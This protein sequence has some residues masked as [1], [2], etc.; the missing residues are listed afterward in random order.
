M[1]EKS[2]LRNHAD[3]LTIV[4][5]N[6]AIAAILITMYVSNTSRIDAANARSDQLYMAL[7]EETLSFHQAIM[8]E[9]QLFHQ[10]VKDFHGRLCAIEE[11]NK[12]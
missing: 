4:G 1:T 9:R 6:L 5:V 10:E 12:K 11:R 8:E 2:F 3:T 7:K